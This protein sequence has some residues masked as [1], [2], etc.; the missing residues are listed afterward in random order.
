M[1]PL[2]RPRR[3][4]RGRAVCPPPPSSASH[5]LAAHGRCGCEGQVECACTVDLRT[6]PVMLKLTCDPEMLSRS[7]VGQ[8]TLHPRPAVHT[9]RHA[10]VRT[11]L[12]APSNGQRWSAKWVENRYTPGPLL[13]LT[14]ATLHRRP[15]PTRFVPPLA[16]VFERWSTRLG[17][18]RVQCDGRVQRAS[19][20]SMG[21][22]G[23]G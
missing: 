13:M 22:V 18:S 20:A 4:F 21:A 7:H 14:R 8:S 3:G 5:P 9:S 15:P 2:T 11:R 19:A 10:L 23:G 6:R 1:V 16:V 12:A 17:V